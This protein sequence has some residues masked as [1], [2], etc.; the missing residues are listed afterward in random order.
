MN[1]VTEIFS[2]RLKTLR[3]DKSQDEVAKGIGISRGALSYYESGERKPDINI[4]YSLSKY[5]G[6]SADYLIGLSDTPSLSPEIKG[7]CDE[8]GLSDKLLEYLKRRVRKSKCFFDENCDEDGSIWD[9]LYIQAVNI[10]LYD[11]NEVMED[12]TAYFFTSF[13]HYSDFYDDYGYYKPINSLELF[14]Y[15]LQAKYSDDY[16]FLSDAIL[17]RVQQG[18]KQ[19]R[20]KYC[21]AISSEI[22]IPE[23][24]T[25]PYE[26][27]LKRIRKCFQNLYTNPG[28]CTP[29]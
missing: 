5:Y 19:I 8:I 22:P 18:L 2:L 15:R 3:G 14:D 17:L 23:N 13:T 16:D 7:L 1:N 25:E 21:Y 29:K 10:L 28:T 11:F 4:L 27:R 24:G 6:V 12:I 26:D 20:D 9:Y